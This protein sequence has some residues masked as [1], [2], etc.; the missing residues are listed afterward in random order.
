MTSWR[1]TFPLRGRS[2]AGRN[3]AMTARG[4]AF[5]LVE[6]VIGILITSMVAVAVGGVARTLSVS[7]QKSDSYAASLQSARIAMLK[8][9]GEIR[10]AKLVTEAVSGELILW[11]DPNASDGMI[12]VSKIVMI[13]LQSNQ[14]IRS[15][16]TYLH[17]L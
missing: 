10:Q 1:D 4:G 16:H 15:Y 11:Q 3:V 6:L 5:T 17:K 12:T 13:K 14:L 8:V 2:R 7:Y 9:Q